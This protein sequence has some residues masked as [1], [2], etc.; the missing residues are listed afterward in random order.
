MRLIISK[1]LAGLCFLIFAHLS[2]SESLFLPLSNNTPQQPGR[3][4]WADLVSADIEASSNFYQKAFGWEVKKSE[5][6]TAYWY[7]FSHG[8]PIA[9]LVYRPNAQDQSIWIKHISTPNIEATLSTAKKLGATITLPPREFK[10]RGIHAII[11]DPQGGIIGMLDSSSG[12]PLENNKPSGAI[13]WAQL[14]SPDPYEAA[15][16]YSSVFTYRSEALTQKKFAN[17]DALLLRSPENSKAYASISKL[18]AAFQ[19]KNRWVAFIKVT[20]L[21]QSLEKTQTLGAQLIYKTQSSE[22]NNNLAIIKDPSGALIG[23]IE[24][25][26]QSNQEMQQ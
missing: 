25:S 14:F 26:N 5:A 6:D 9:G 11:I 3:F 21:K 15:K 24:P 23:L 8:Q 18:P 1:Y 4:I 20:S 16:F 22:L 12:D 19:Q 10:Q 13:V 17:A 7:L 2:Y